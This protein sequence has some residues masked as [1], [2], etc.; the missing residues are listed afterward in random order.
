MWNFQP[1]AITKAMVILAI[2]TRDSLSISEESFKLEAR[3]ENKEFVKLPGNIVNETQD[4]KFNYRHFNSL[5]IGDSRHQYAFFEIRSNIDRGN[6]TRWC[7]EESFRSKRKNLLVAKSCNS[8]PSQKWAID[9][10]GYLYNKKMA[11]KC[12]RRGKFLRFGSCAKKNDAFLKWIFA[13]DQTIRWSNNALLT[14]RIPSRFVA[15]SWKRVASVECRRV[16][17]RGPFPNERW[18]FIF[19]EIH[20]RSP[21]VSP[22]KTP[23]FSPIASSNPSSQHTLSRNPASQSPMGPPSSPPSP[24]KK[25]NITLYKVGEKTKFDDAFDQAKLRWENII[26]GDLE[27][28]AAQKNPEYDWFGGE[29]DDIQVNIPIDDVLIGYEFK[30]ID[31]KGK[32]LGMAGPKTARIDR[33]TS[34]TISGVMM[35]EEI[36][37]EAMTEEDRLLVVMHEMGHVLGLGTYLSIHCGTECVSGN[38]IYSCEKASTEY[39]K[40]FGNQN[41]SLTLEPGTCAHW[42]ED[43]FKSSSKSELMTPY[44]EKGKYQP[45][46]RVTVAALADIGYTVNMH[47]ADPWIKHTTSLSRKTR[48]TIK[49]SDRF[50][51]LVPSE[52]FNLENKMT[53]PTMF[54]ITE[55]VQNI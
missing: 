35:F 43:A 17:G 4:S 31:G 8:S 26:V 34:T 28:Y 46:S 2:Y 42:S 30:Y 5:D 47:A 24:S 32:I 51:I 1:L 38:N 52:T 37:F 13:S 27:D 54:N 45:I 19:D 40:L 29:W 50:D 53:S 22:S 41:A 10:N 18:E 12:I 11:N 49:G 16:I 6:M 15:S 23:S 44:F 36:D 14:I 7:L 25:F 21:S 48:A 33:E 20:T 9:S 39:S 3:S 55:D